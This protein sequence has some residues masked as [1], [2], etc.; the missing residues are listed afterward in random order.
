MQQET[1]REKTFRVRWPSPGSSP[2]QLLAQHMYLLH[3]TLSDGPASSQDLSHLGDNGVVV[4]ASHSHHLITPRAREQRGQGSPNMD[5]SITQKQ[6]AGERQGAKE[7]V[8]CP[9]VGAVTMMWDKDRRG[10]GAG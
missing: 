6:H 4:H 10:G 2:A 7:N 8:T 3:I 5:V 1:E 9:E